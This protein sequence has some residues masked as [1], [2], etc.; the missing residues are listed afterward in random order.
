MRRSGLVLGAAFLGALG[1][2]FAER[3][4]RS[5]RLRI[6]V[7]GHSMQPGLMEGDWLLV[8]PARNMPRPG[9]V[10]VAHDP[11]QR[12]RLI[13]KR[14]LA[15]GEDGSLSVTGDHPAHLEEAAAIGRIAPDL[16]VG[17]PCFRYWPLSRVAFL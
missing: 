12:E 1:I 16:I 10:I 6:A 7:S 14:V 9:E 17:R 8:E 15:V 11:R 3:V 4:A 5:W 13:V 2:P